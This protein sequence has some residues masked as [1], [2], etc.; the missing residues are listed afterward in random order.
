MFETFPDLE[1]IKTSIDIVLP[2]LC[3]FETFPDLEGIKTITC[4]T[5][6]HLFHV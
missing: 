1:G 6:H 4:I 2:S 5:Q 3:G